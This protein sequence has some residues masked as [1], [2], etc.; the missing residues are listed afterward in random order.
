ME[1]IKVKRSLVSFIAVAKVNNVPLTEDQ[2]NHHFSL[3]EQDI[4]ENSILYLS[5]KVGLKSKATSL[6]IAKLQDLSLPALVGLK[7][8]G[9]VVL[10]RVD[11]ESVTIYDPVVGTP[12]EISFEKFEE[13]WTGRIILVKNKDLRYQRI[14]FGI[15]WFL[16]TIFKYKK[17]FLDVLLAAFTIQIL[18][19]V[20]PLVTQAVIDKVL[21]HK[22]YNTLKVLMIGLIIIIIFETLM[23]LARNYVFSHTTNKVDVILNSRLFDHLFKLPFMYFQSRRVGD[24]IARVREVENIRRFLTGTPLTAIL[25]VLFIVVYVIVMYMYN[26]ML[27]NIQLFSLVFFVIL[28]VIATPMFKN[29]LDK[30]FSA[31]AEMQSFLVESVSGVETIKSLALE[32]MSQRR[33]EDRVADY[34]EASFKTAILSGNVGAIGSL[35]QK[36]TDVVLLWVGTNMVMKGTISIGQLIA[37]RMLSGRVSGP[38]LRIVSLWQEFQQVSVSIERLADIFNAVPEP[39]ADADKMKLPS[40]KGR[41]EFH[42][43]TFRYKPG[44]PEA[45]KDFTLTIPHG[46]VVGIVGRSGSGKSTLSKL[47]QRLYIPESGKIM[48]DGVDLS[49]AD[50]HWLRRQI[51]VVLQENFLFNGSV[52]DN[53]CI[54]KPSAS[55]EE[56]IRCA[57]LAGAHKF[58]LELPQGYDTPVGEKGT[59]LSGGQRQRIAIARALITDPKILIFDEAT[60]ALD[61][62][63][64][65]I[66]QKN[67]KQICKGRTVL[68]IAHRLSTIKDSDGIIVMDRGRLIEFG[69]HKNL[70]DK[71]GLYHHLFS[72]QETMQVIDE[73]EEIVDSSEGMGV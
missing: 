45:V 27:T 71:G 49:M 13:I 7:D 65:S 63:S 44:I 24:T 64:E 32:P 6:S 26:T 11:R 14:K 40:I 1:D 18:G 51:G 38:I 67:L 28:S 60:S 73:V 30:K 43:L 57:M 55:M 2:L 56:V 58:I 37:F 19:L 8:G 23:S 22:A 50:P 29:Q 42:G 70:I 33:W 31:G 66:I 21:S 68:I 4:D 48:I 47:I 52:K 16:P 54:H 17:A 39:Y 72:Q 59:A 41:I 69:N 10:A 34:T 35:I 9:F 15:K 20:S 12:E 36:I 53:I 25:D 46:K 61:Y 3:N 5:K 62:E